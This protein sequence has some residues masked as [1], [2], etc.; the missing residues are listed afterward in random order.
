M[1]GISINIHR[2]SRTTSTDSVA[3]AVYQINAPSCRKV[4]VEG[5]LNASDI[6]VLGNNNTA[7]DIFF[8]EIKFDEP[9]VLQGKIT[10]KLHF[11]NCTFKEIKIGQLLTSDLRLEFDGC[12]IEKFIQESSGKL[13]ELALLNECKIGNLHLA[14]IQLRIKVNNSIITNDWLLENCIIRRITINGLNGNHNINFTSG[15]VNNL[16]INNINI[17]SISF[18]GFVISNGFKLTKLNKMLNLFIEGCSFNDYKLIITETSGAFITISQCRMNN[19]GV[20]NINSGSFGYPI[21]L[22]DQCNF[23]HCIDIT[24]TNHSKIRITNT[25]FN[26]LVVFSKKNPKNLIIEN[27][28]F[29][30]GLMIPIGDIYPLY[31]HSSVWCV[32]KNQALQSN[33]RI[34][35]LDYRKLEMDAYTRELFSKPKKCQE[36]TIL[37]LN[38]ISNNHGL[39]WT[40]GLGFTLG[41][42]L[43]FY[44][45]YY[46]AEN[47]FHL[48]FNHI[49]YNNFK[50]FIINALQFLWLPEGIN[51]LPKELKGSKNWYS[52][53]IMIL[54]FF[55][56]KILIAY[57]IYQTVAAFRKHGK[58]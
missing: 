30:N 26:E 7:V 32:L 1:E 38:K 27:T 28:S 37:I 41:I 9:V 54:S 56:G 42:V 52:F 11:V 18:K 24:N 16:D 17:N 46:I 31:V 57:G 25:V 14:N 45:L 50:E 33:D 15:E 40:R 34:K 8:R 19:K 12:T 49:S 44:Y 35:A 36:K 23:S 39:S 2:D 13:L 21:L 10:S 53:I 6:S 4:E 58:I 47:N 48:C 20:F 51:D 55:I 43:V 29:Q 5:N 22:I 3:D